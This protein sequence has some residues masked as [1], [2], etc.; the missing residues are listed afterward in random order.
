MIKKEE[1][2]LQ[3]REAVEKFFEKYK[4]SD[5]NK[6]HIDT[7]FTKFLDKCEAFNLPPRPFGIV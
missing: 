1:N 6:V 4:T 2:K 5:K 7:A 3:E